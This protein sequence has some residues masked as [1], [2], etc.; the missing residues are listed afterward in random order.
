MATRRYLDFR[1]DVTDLTEEEADHLAGE[2]ITQSESSERHP[3]VPPPE[4]ES[5]EHHV[6]DDCEAELDP[7]EE[8]RGLCASCLRPRVVVRLSGDQVVGVD[9]S[10]ARV[11][12][13]QYH[14]D[15]HAD[16]STAETDEQGAYEVLWTRGDGSSS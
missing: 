16:P 8:E 7:G 5:V 6:C 12:V 3:D 2:V 9:P 13:R 10:G 15:Y 1:F 14:A 11:E 4:V